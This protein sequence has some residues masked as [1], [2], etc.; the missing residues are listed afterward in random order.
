VDKGFDEIIKKMQ[1]KRELLKKDFEERYTS[2]DA[3]YLDK[4]SSLVQN[5]S[6][7]SNIEAIYDE[8]KSFIERNSDAKVLSKISDISSFMN[9]SIED[10]ERITKM[11]GFEKP[12]LTI[13]PSLHPMTLNVQ[14]VL[15]II[16]KFNMVQPKKPAAV[17]QQ[18]SDVPTRD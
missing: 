12:D 10:L 16:N 9:K 13:D 5:A 1:D 17:Q 7:V 2:A 18:A 11:R 6:E 8:L 14:K 3:I 15:D 4:E